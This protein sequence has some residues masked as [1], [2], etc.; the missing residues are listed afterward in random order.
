MPMRLEPRGHLD[1]LQ[2]WIPR[3]FFLR[4]DGADDA[5]EGRDVVA[6]EGCDLLPLVSFVETENA[7]RKHFR[8]LG[9]AGRCT[10]IP[11]PIPRGVTLPPER[12]ERE[13]FGGLGVRHWGPP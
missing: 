11:L 6:V 3:R 1:L 5:G 9:S 4:P 2:R 10:G 7:N 13:L 12:R 8:V